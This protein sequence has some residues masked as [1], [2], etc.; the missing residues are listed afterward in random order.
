[1]LETK[2]SSYRF[3]T[4]FSRTTIPQLK[5]NEV[6]KQDWKYVVEKER[7]HREVWEGNK[8][9]VE[10]MSYTKRQ[11]MVWVLSLY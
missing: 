3:S 4:I 6:Y 10:T 2:L 8:R 9:I 11:L 5:I 1:L 7:N